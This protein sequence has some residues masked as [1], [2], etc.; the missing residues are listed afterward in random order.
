MGRRMKGSEM[1]TRE[2]EKNLLRAGS[3][4]SR[5]T[6]GSVAAGSVPLFSE[7][8]TAVVAGSTCA[9]RRP[10]N[11]HLGS[12]LKLVLPIY[13]DLLAGLEAIVDE[14]FAAFR[15]RDF[16]RAQ[17]HGL[18]GPDEKCVST[19]RAALDH[20]GGDDDAIRWF[21]PR[22]GKWNDKK[23]KGLF[24]PPDDDDWILVVKP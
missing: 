14:R 22:S 12:G 5:A 4:R 9:S 3:R 1:F 24:A 20:A 7:R 19:V 15:L 10:L 6:R 21:N 13:D 17:F 2:P 16:N 11:F 8:A 23:P 18:I